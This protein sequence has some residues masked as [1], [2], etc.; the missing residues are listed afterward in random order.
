MNNMVSDHLA[1]QPG[2]G[3]DNIISLFELIEIALYT[4]QK[5]NNYPQSC[6]KTVDNYFHLLFPDE[7]KAYMHKREIN[8]KTFEKINMPCC[9]SK[10]HLAQVMSLH[11]RKVKETRALCQLL[12]EQQNN[13]LLLISNKLDEL[14][15]D[16][17]KADAD[18]EC[19]AYGK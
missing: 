7:I 19:A 10:R 9:Q 16:L 11:A 8:T 15:I 18:K 6:E 5:I 12:V 17:I 14:E 13:I 2:T 1:D 4:V 3:A